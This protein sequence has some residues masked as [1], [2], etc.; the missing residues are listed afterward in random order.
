MPRVESWDQLP[1]LIRKHLIDRMRSRSISL[2]DL[3]KVMRGKRR[4][5]SYFH[6]AVKM[7][8]S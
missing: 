1:A 2:D 5:G 4:S 3:N 6:S 7:L 8:N